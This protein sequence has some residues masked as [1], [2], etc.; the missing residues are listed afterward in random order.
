M[1]SSGVQVNECGIARA[2]AAA[3]RG[4]S[5]VADVSPGHH[6]EV[7]TYGPGEKVRGVAVTRAAGALDISVHL[8]AMHA[9]ALILPDL[10]IRV[11]T[12]VRAAT[13]ALG[14]GAVRRIDVTFDDLRVEEG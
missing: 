14:A 7:A 12:V 4:V 8:C 6:A 1:D 13:N 2:V 3:V 9:D 5:G 10:A 11:R